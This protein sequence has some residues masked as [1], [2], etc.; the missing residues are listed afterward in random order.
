MSIKDF[1]FIII[2]SG[3]I[4]LAIARSLAEGGYKSVLVIDKN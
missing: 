2:G 3:V 4:G 1:Q